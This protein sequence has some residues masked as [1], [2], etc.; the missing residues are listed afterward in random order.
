M[1]DIIAKYKNI[2]EE[3]T[4][5]FKKDSSKFDAFLITSRCISELSRLSLIIQKEI[6]LNNT[7][8]N[9]KELLEEKDNYIENNILNEE[10]FKKA[11]LVLDDLSK[12]KITMEEFARK[13]IFLDIEYS[14]SDKVELKP[15]ETKLENFLRVINTLKRETNIEDFKYP[16]IKEY[17]KKSIECFDLAG[18]N[19]YFLKDCY[20]HFNKLGFELSNEE[21][22]LFLN[23]NNFRK[24]HNKDEISFS[25]LVRK[26][27]EIKENTAV[28]YKLNTDCEIYT[29]VFFTLGNEIFLYKFDLKN[30][31]WNKDKTLI[32]EVLSEIEQ[33]GLKKFIKEENIDK[34]KGLL[35][36]NSQREKIGQNYIKTDD[37]ILAKNL[38][39]N[40]EILNI[41]NEAI[42]KDNDVISS[43]KSFKR[44]DRN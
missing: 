26:K 18:S 29:E 33:I 6:L 4:N 12:K 11:I 27:S 7:V 32:N 25:E 14:I 24:I 5:F 44:K 3:I 10:Y 15:K 38:T 37:L 39:D 16:F 42:I 34:L 17:V 23:I 31:T 19:P 43:E 20:E 8:L 22:D 13:S 30:K 2:N 35:D 1:E 28:L 21:A 41:L 9:D 36:I 40:K